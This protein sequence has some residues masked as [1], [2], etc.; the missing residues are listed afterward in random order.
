MGSRFMKA[1]IKEKKAYCAKKFPNST[2]HQNAQVTKL[3]T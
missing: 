1:K 2:R 3:P